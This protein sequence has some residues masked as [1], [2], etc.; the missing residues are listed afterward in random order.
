[1]RHDTYTDAM[2]CNSSL[3]KEFESSAPLQEY[4]WGIRILSL[5]RLRGRESRGFGPRSLGKIAGIAE[6]TQRELRLEATP[7]ER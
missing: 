7:I 2:I 5:V 6:I 1:V 3:A 4:S